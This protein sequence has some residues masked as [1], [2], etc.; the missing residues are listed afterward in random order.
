[1]VR[2]AYRAMRHPSLRHR[3]WWK[4]LT[5]TI[6]ERR[7]WKPCRDTVAGGLSIGLFFG[8]MP[9]PFQSVIAAVIAAR[10]KM[11]IPFAIVSTWITNPLTVVP[12]WLFQ[13]SFGSWLRHSLGFPMPNFLEKVHFNVPITDADMNAASFILGFMITGIIG[14]LIAF[15]LTHL[16]SAILPHHLPRLPQ[17]HRNKRPSVPARDSGNSGK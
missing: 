13:E 11:N 16:F 14:A 3:P 8:M 1:M 12:I 9:I 5:R 7:L 4:A 15:P 6:F 2:R 17:L 10:A